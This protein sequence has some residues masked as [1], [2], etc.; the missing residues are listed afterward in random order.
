MSNLSWA[1]LHGKYLA[2]GLGQDG[3]LENITDYE[4]YL[5]NRHF[6]CTKRSFWGPRGKSEKLFGYLKTAPYDDQWTKG[7]AFS[8]FDGM[9]F[10]ISANNRPKTIFRQVPNPSKRVISAD[11]DKVKSRN[12]A[13]LRGASQALSF[14]HFAFVYAKNTGASS[15]Y[16][17]MHSGSSSSDPEV[18]DQTPEPDSRDWDPKGCFRSGRSNADVAFAAADAARAA[19]TA[20][21]DRAGLLAARAAAADDDDLAAAA[22]EAA[23]RAR[24]MAGKSAAADA[25]AGVFVDDDLKQ[26][27]TAQDNSEVME[28]GLE[29]EYDH[30]YLADDPANR[31][32]GGA[33]SKSQNNSTRY[34]QRGLSFPWEQMIDYLRKNQEKEIQVFMGDKSQTLSRPEVIRGVEQGKFWVCFGKK[35]GTVVRKYEGKKQLSK[36]RMCGVDGCELLPDPFEKS[37]VGVIGEFTL[38]E[39]TRENLQR[40]SEGILGQ[41]SGGW[42]GGIKKLSREKEWYITTNWINDRRFQGVYDG[43]ENAWIAWRIYTQQP[44]Q[45][46][47]IHFAVAAW[48]WCSRKKGRLDN[49][50]FCD[51]HRSLCGLSL[52]KK[53]ICGSLVTKQ[54]VLTDDI[55]LLDLGESVT[56]KDGEKISP[57]DVKVGYW[58]PRDLLMVVEILRLIWWEKEGD[59]LSNW[60]TPFAAKRVP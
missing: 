54:K 32:G 26:K 37:T 49:D 9:P 38:P 16:R 33:S 31:D 48:M 59:D 40:A 7:Y 52:T 11:S 21:E 25:A 12:E 23:E 20:A 42:V 4:D 36:V 28:G 34:E 18:S 22:A 60:W 14:P 46:N 58:T 19:A 2:I 56:N 55:Q 45:Y 53:V 8:L 24:E 1:E 50:L 43:P 39:E 51:I 27:D 5:L 13:A 35:C 41:L 3:K 6:R 15:K 30:G 57:D 29:P 17:S 47:Y 44:P 10:Q